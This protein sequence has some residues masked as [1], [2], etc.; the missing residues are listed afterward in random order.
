[1]GENNVM[2]EPIEENPLLVLYREVQGNIARLM[3]SPPTDIEGVRSEMTGTALSLL[4]DTVKIA[5]DMTD[6]LFES[7]ERAHDRLDA[8]TG[9]ATQF[10][11]EDAEK[12]DFVISAAVALAKGALEAEGVTEDRRVELR[13]VVEAGEECL[14]QIEETTLDED[15][16]EDEG[17]EAAPVAIGQA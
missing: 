7:V 15:E 10:K 14:K 8:M 12:F 6:M 2:Q 3:R 11:P 5:A 9:G 17:E 13:K 16:E 4:R 1:M